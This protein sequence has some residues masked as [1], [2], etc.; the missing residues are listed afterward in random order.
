MCIEQGTQQQQ[1][2][3]IKTAQ[4]QEQRRQQVQAETHQEDYMA[5]YL[6]QKGGQY[7]QDARN[8]YLAQTAHMQ[9]TAQLG[10]KS[11]KSNTQE[12]KLRNERIDRAKLMTDRA[13]AYTLDVY[14]Q[15]KEMR[16]KQQ[17]RKQARAQEA[18]NK[19]VVLKTMG[20]WQQDTTE[21]QA[22][23]LTRMWVVESH[24]YSPE[25]FLTS[26]I[27]KKENFM[28]YYTWIEEYE[29]LME[30]YQK[31]QDAYAPYAE[32]IQGLV[33][34]L[35][36]V[37]DALR[38]RLQ[39]FCEQ[40]RVS[41]K[42]EILDETAE[43][44]FLS[45]TDITDWFE[46][47]R[48][49]NQW[50][51]HFNVSGGPLTDEERENFRT[52]RE[53][54][55]RQENLQNRQ[56][57]QPLQRTRDEAVST[58]S[59]LLEQRS[60]QELR[61]LNYRLYEAGLTDVAKTVHAYVL[62]TRYEV[63][64][65]EERKR[66]QKAIAAV[67]AALEKTDNLQAV[68]LLN[69]MKDYFAQMTNGTLQIPATAQIIDCSNKELKE[70][71]GDGGGSTRNAMIR[72]AMR[73]S[74]QKDTPLFSHEPV[75][76]DLKQ[77][78]VSNCYMVAS[79]CGLVNLN[80]AVLKECIKDNGDGTVT[81]R[82]Y[83]NE[84]VKKEKT[85]E[86]KPTEGGLGDDPEGPDDFEF[87]DMDEIEQY[88]L[89]PVYVKVSK[90]I[91]RIAGADA[92]SAG[93]LWM[94][95]IEKACAY[96]GRNRRT[97]YQSLWYGEGGS[98]LERLLGIPRELVNK[99]TPEDQD[100]LFDGI[101]HASENQIVYHAGTY[102]EKK[103]AGGNDTDGLNTGHAYAVL[104]GKVENGQKY[105][106][107]RNPYSTHSLQYKED[108]VRETTGSLLSVSSDETYGQFYMKF[109]EFVRDFQTVSLTD[110]KK[111]PA[112]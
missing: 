77:R 70:T 82:L 64:Y 49:F 78:L 55:G 87:I 34:H 68:H 57:A 112:L 42:G 12:K 16:E 79:T 58:P 61:R 35:G 76:N 46:K 21:Q 33:E 91:P 37:I 28:R 63:G 36:P 3:Q 39:V 15:M 66:L 19:V 80:P 13:T 59:D 69:N 90:E 54:A 110:L 108:N 45:D 103:A 72:G 38:H 9:D 102:N 14:D 18:E 52:M 32:D 11:F 104:G 22:A 73:W 20:N 7:A 25:M 53:E 85:A 30:A 96:L 83:E 1:Q 89:R 23:F 99:D 60:R 65:T 86:Q 31:D 81:V 67:N 24:I 101:C 74:N 109:E 51:H 100:A 98:F 94:Q 6:Q 106:L 4:V 71:G 48:E 62:G 40:N 47:V 92:L 26:N 95:M 107:L 27:Q 2:A 8:A 41:L 50:K 10:K 44:A 56:N 29:E 17:M 5:Q 105:V 43:S 111:K 88:E 93:A 75:T 97:G 84:P